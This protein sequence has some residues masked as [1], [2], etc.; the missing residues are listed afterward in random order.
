M[1]GGGSKGSECAVLLPSLFTSSLDRSLFAPVAP[2][3][4]TL[5]VKERGEG[6][7]APTEADDT[8]S[9]L[10]REVL[11]QHCS[12]DFHPSPRP[13]HAPRVRASPTE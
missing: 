11:I 6:Q 1:G 10:S 3:D 12:I 2:C 13:P 7:I 4:F 9:F 8:V 5:S